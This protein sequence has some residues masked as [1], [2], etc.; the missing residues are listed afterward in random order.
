MKNADKPPKAYKQSPRSS[1][2]DLHADV[3]ALPM[4]DWRRGSRALM[5]ASVKFSTILRTSSSRHLIS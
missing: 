3:S 4:S 2:P 5:M 1:T